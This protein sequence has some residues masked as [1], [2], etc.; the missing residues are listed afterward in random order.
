MFATDASEFPQETN[1]TFKVIYQIGDVN[2]RSVI[3]ALR[4]IKLS[5]PAQSPFREPSMMLVRR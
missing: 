1:V 4:T 5:P 3:D 2:L